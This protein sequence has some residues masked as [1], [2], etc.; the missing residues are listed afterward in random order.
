MFALLWLCLWPDVT[1]RDCGIQ[2]SSVFLP[3]A[4]GVSPPRFPT[5]ALPWK[6]NACNKPRSV[7]LG[8]LMLAC[9]RSSP[10][11]LAASLPHARAGACPVPR[12]ARPTTQ[13]QLAGPWCPPAPLVHGGWEGVSWAL[14]GPGAEPPVQPPQPSSMSALGRGDSQGRL[15]PGQ[16][17]IC[18]LQS[19]HPLQ[20]SDGCGGLTPGGIQG[21]PVPSGGSGMACSPGTHCAGGGRLCSPAWWGCRQESPPPRTRRTRVARQQEDAFSD[22]NSQLAAGSGGGGT[23]PGKAGAARGG[24]QGSPRPESSQNSVEENQLLLLHSATSCPGPSPSEKPG[25]LAGDSARPWDLL[26]VSGTGQGQGSPYGD[27]PRASCLGNPPQGSPGPTTHP[28]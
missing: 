25:A 17:C 7:C 10:G 15:L 27:S 24:I 2:L 4:V 8:R 6:T 26:L 20:G 9:S 22:Q 5:D 11:S 14:A 28:A 1:T 12:T 19:C 13:G 23:G 3:V 21:F 16:R 18:A